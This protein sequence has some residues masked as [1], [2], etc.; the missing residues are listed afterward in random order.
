MT[1]DSRWYMHPGYPADLIAL[2]A[3]PGVPYEPGQDWQADE[4]FHPGETM[5]RF[6]EEE[7][8]RR[9]PNYLPANHGNEAMERRTM[10]DYVTVGVSECHIPGCF[11]FE[12]VFVYDDIG[13]MVLHYCDAVIPGPI[14][15]TIKGLTGYT[16]EEFKLLAFI[17]DTIP[18]ADREPIVEAPD[19][20]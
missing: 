9:A 18:E 15:S 1:N 8:Q 3:P 20:S 6:M 2:P 5:R 17:Y 7:F 19:N 12:W 14:E 4:V 16:L 11:G 13:L 10:D